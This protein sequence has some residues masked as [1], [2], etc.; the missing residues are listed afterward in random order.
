[1][2]RICAAAQVPIEVFGAG[3][4]RAGGGDYLSAMRRFAD[5]WARPHWRM[6]CAALQHLVT[7]TNPATG[8]TSPVRPPARLWYDVADIAALREGELERGQA[9]LVRAQA[10][11]TFVAAGYTRDSAVAAADSGD[12]SQLKADPNA[13]PGVAGRPPQAGVPQALPGV[14][15]PNLPDAQPQQFQPMPGMPNGARG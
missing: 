3:V 8:E 1:V 10:V 2:Q 5:L 4:W 7:I 6:A 9:V 13:A 15:R 12:L 11:S 14:V